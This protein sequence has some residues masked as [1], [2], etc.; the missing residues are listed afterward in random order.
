MLTR[1]LVGLALS[2]AVLVPL[3]NLSLPLA[4]ALAQANQQQRQM[5]ILPAQDTPLNAVLGQ[6][7]RQAFPQMTPLLLTQAQSVPPGPFLA[8]FKRW[9]KEHAGEL[10][11]LQ[12]SSMVRVGELDVPGFDV[13]RLALAAYALVPNWSQGP[14]NLTGPHKRQGQD[15]EYWSIDVESVLTLNLSVFKTSGDYAQLAGAPTQSWTVRKEIPIPDMD[16]LVAL[17]SQATG[18]EVDLNSPSQ[19]ALVL[20]TLKKVQTF[21]EI[22]AAEPSAYLQDEIAQ[23]VSPARFETLVAGLQSVEGLGNKTAEAGQQPVA[24]RK[25]GLG[26]TPMLKFGT[27]TVGVLGFVPQYFVPQGQLDLE[28]DFGA[29]FGWPELMLTVSGGAT[30]PQPAYSLLAQP[31]FPGFGIPG[32]GL[33]NPQAQI[34]A[35]NAEMGLLKRFSFGQWSFSAGLRGGMM[36]AVIMQANGP[37]PNPLQPDPTAMAFGGTAL[38]G[39][40]YRFTPEFMLG[41]DAGFRYFDGGQWTSNNAGFPSSFTPLIQNPLQSIGPV[42][43]LYAGYTF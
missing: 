32:G 42:L 36:G 4:P 41:I 13:R 8:E 34:L 25:G 21:Q 12:D 28:Y 30:L 37:F 6:V 39:A 43:G 40:A 26:L 7:L 20:D 17:V 22:Q 2:V 33:P 11:L 38:L 31:S 23:Q 18:V 29:L 19:A 16:R 9:Q 1:S 3:L 5:A 27:G 15:G 35:Y 24:P 14:L 10:P